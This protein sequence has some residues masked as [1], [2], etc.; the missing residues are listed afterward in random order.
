MNTCWKN[1]CKNVRKHIDLLREKKV[2][3]CSFFRMLPHNCA[4]GALNWRD[5]LL[6]IAFY[7]HRL[8]SN[9][10]LCTVR[11]LNVSMYFSISYWSQNEDNDVYNWSQEQQ[12]I[13]LS[14]F[15]WGYFITQIPGGIFSQR[16]GGKY[17]FMLGIMFS[18]VCSLLTPNVIRL[19]KFFGRS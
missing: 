3:F 7:W 12:G 2:R 11:S 8:K 18:A 10:P 4:A 19:G 14:S 15:F 6:W 13:I 17:V 16:Y 1:N 5:A 9:R